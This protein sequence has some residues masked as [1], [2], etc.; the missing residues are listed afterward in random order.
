MESSTLGQF[1]ASRLLEVG[2][3]HIFGVPGDFNL[4]LLDQ[5]VEKDG[6]ETVW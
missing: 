4:V 1:L 2:V 5:F 3:T 6:L